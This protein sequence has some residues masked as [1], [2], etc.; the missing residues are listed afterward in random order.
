MV[1]VAKFHIGFSELNLK[2]EAV[3]DSHI[4]YK[5]DFIKLH[6]SFMRRY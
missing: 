1:S 6:C 5:S 2:W 4:Q 3:T